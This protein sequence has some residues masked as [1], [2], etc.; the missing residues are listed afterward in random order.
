MYTHLPLFASFAASRELTGAV[1]DTASREEREAAKCDWPKGATDGRPEI[2]K[3]EGFRVRS[4]S[5]VRCEV[6]T[7]LQSLLIPT[8]PPIS[9]DLQHSRKRNPEE[10]FIT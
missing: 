4:V 8:K 10:E 7:P 1:N 9:P 2:E 6:T 3:P 5:T